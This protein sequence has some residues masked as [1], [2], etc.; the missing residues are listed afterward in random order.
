MQ[1]IT[2]LSIDAKQ[3]FKMILDDNTQ[4][5]F[6]FQYRPN[7]LGWFF[8]LVWGD[9]Q[10]YGIRLTTAPN[11][12]RGYK[13]ILP[14]GLMVTTNDNDEPYSQDDFVSG[15]CNL[16]LLNPTDILAVE[17]NYYAKN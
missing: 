2:T 7:Q 12:L 16:Y 6:T 1:Q 15:Y 8:D 11:L 5:Q 13:N 17:A 10:K 14:F 3:N 4:V 9:I